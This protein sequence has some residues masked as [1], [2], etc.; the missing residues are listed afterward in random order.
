[1]RGLRNLAA[2]ILHPRTLCLSALAAVSVL[3]AV[4]GFMPTGPKITSAV[5]AR[6]VAELTGPSTND[7]QVTRIVTALMRREHL[8]KHELDDEIS[9]R[10]LELFL[11]SLDNMKLYFYQSDVDEFAAKKNE[12][13]DMVR[14]GDISFAYTVFSRLLKRIDE[15]VALVD[16]LLK[17]DFDFTTDESLIT[18][19]DK[20]SYPK[21]PEEARERWAKRLKYDLLLLK[22]EKTAEKKEGAAP[23]NNEDPRE[24]LKRRYHSFAKRMHQTDS[25]ELLEMYLSA[26]TNGFDP[27][28]TYMAPASSENFD[29]IMS[30]Q[31]EGI[32]AQLKVDDGHTVI[33]KLIPGGAAAKQGELKVGDRVVS[34]GQ[35]E[36]GAQVDVA[37]MKLNDV[38]K[39][40]RGR[41]GSVVKLGVESGAEGA[42]KIIKI[43]RAKVELKDSEARAQIIEAGKKSDGATFKIGVIDL[44]SFYMD[45]TRARDGTA[46]F[47]SCSRDVRRI[48]DD[49]NTKGVDAVVLDLRRNGGGSLTEA[50]NLTGLFIDKGPVV[51]VKDPDGRVQHYDY[52][53]RGIVWKGPLVVMTSKFSASASEILAGAIQDYRRGL[54]IGDSSTHGKGTVQTMVD[55]GPQMFRIANPPDLGSLKLTVQQFYRPSGDSTQQRG[56][57]AD[58]TLPSITDH[59][60]VAEGDLDYPVAFDK[61]AETPFEKFESVSPNIVGTLKELASE[62]MNKSSEFQKLRKDI[63]RFVEQKAKKEVPLNEQKFMARRAELDADKEEEKTF[64]HQ[65]NGDSDQEVFKRTYYNNEILNITLDYLRLL[66]KDKVAQN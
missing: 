31:L 45:M 33:D 48:L 9:Q 57:L 56:V 20:L 51:Q 3:A 25:N 38:V 37:E 61:V 24:R 53:D 47:K 60:D 44:P 15:R 59:M 49:F 14:A 8:S 22:A 10:G 28:S 58:I 54:V 43:V 32:G 7:R 36:D 65:A 4:A 13:D 21:S 5:E 66:G 34:V 35:G 16:E 12:L 17:Q 42:L 62:R 41:A 27:H 30:L 63:E 11:K 19:P 50:I 46:D 26:I 39:L 6:P 29:I 23:P 1:M 55:L 64:D 52:H 40:I 2:S 18:D